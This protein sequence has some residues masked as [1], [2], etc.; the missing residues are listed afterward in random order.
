MS[1][2]M[3]SRSGTK[4]GRKR[5]GRKKALKSLSSLSIATK[6]GRPRKA[7]VLRK[8]SRPHSGSELDSP[9]TSRREQGSTEPR[10]NVEQPAAHGAAQGTQPA[11]EA[12]LREYAAARLRSEIKEAFLLRSMRAFVDLVTNAEDPVIR[13]ALEAPSAAGGLG[14]FVAVAV[15]T[16]PGVDAVDPLASSYARAAERKRGLLERA[17]GA[18]GATDVGL[19]LGISRQA[20]DKRRAE[21]KL[22]AIRNASGDYLYPSCQFL[23]QGNVLPHLAEYLQICGFQDPWM[24]LQLLLATPETL[25]G[26]LTVRDALR[27]ADVGLVA[28]AL[29]VARGAGEQGA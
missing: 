15:P 29:R 21:G 5:G 14:R 8:V 7:Y 22:L 11:L 17:G 2:K 9:A 26:T 27:S 1:A 12:L 23:P 28:E 25:G 13:G 24:Q 16:A 10:T 20:V 3:K 6:A 18:I 19:L 4:G